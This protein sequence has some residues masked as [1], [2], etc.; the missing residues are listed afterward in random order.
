MKSFLKAAVLTTL[1]TLFLFAIPAANG[2]TV[3]KAVHFTSKDDGFRLQGSYY[4]GS[5][6]A[7]GILLLHQCDRKETPTGYEGLAD[8]LSKQ[9]F[10]VL[11]LDFRGYGGSKNELFDGKNW[12]EAQTFFRADTESAYQ[13]L[14]SQPGVI[15]DR[16]GVAGASCGGRQA[17]FLAADHPEIKALVFVSSGVGG[18]SE[19]AFDKLAALP[20]VAITGESDRLAVDSTKRLFER[21]LHTDSRL[22]IY[23]GSA[24]GTPLFAID[25]FLRSVVAHWFEKVLDRNEKR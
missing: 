11:A 2:Q 19:A 17:I 8:L 12:Q 10:N 23:K 13:F 25:P 3:A 6:R 4:G 18:P 5:K 1:L 20:I 16:I 14:I 9:G 15:R 24:H 22:L 21:S 7:P